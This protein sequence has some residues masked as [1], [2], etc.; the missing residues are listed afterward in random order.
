[1]DHTDTQRLDPTASLIP[2]LVLEIN[3]Q[4]LAFC[5]GEGQVKMEAESGAMQSPVKECLEPS[6]AGRG[7]KDP[8]PGP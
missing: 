1:M 6:E 4:T 8:P 2:A 7:E 3:P 5:A